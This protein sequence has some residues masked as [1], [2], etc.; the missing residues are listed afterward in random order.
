MILL[1]DESLSNVI[2]KFYDAVIYASKHQW[3]DP[4]AS[5]QAKIEMHQWFKAQISKV[6]ESVQKI[7]ID[8]PH[9]EDTRSGRAMDYKNGF[10]SAIQQVLEM[11]K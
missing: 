8:N 2:N 9:K 7:E 5:R 10:D 4:D 6:S 3:S 1:T 11:L